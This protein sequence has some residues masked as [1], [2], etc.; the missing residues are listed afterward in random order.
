MDVHVPTKLLAL[1]VP[2]FLFLL[3]SNAQTSSN[4]IQLG[5]SIVAG[6]NKSWTSPSADFAF[7]FYPLPHGR[8][9]VGIWFDKINPQKTLVWSANRDDPAQIGS[10]INLTLSG[11][12]VLLHANGS[13][14]SIYNQ[15]NNASS[16]SMLDNGNFVLKNSLSNI[17]WESFASPT[18]TILPGQNLVM[19]QILYSNANGTLDYSTGNYKLEVQSDGNIVIAA[20]RYSGHAYWFTGTIENNSVSIVFDNNTAMLYAVNGTRNIYQMTTQS[21]LPNPIEDFYH[22]ATINDHGNF[23]QL[24]FHKKNGTEWTLIWDAITEPCLVDAICGVNGFCTSPDNKVINCSCLPGY[25]PLDPYVPSKGCYR[26][27]EMDFCAANSSASDFTVQEI[28]DADIPNLNFADM[29][30]I[31]NSDL[32]SCTREVM[33]DCFCM[34]GVLIGTDCF[35]K[36]TPLLNGRI[37]IPT[38]SKRVALVKVPVVRKDDGNDSPSWIVLL[39]SF[40]SCSLLALVF[41]ASAVHHNPKFRRWIRKEPPPNPKPVDINLKTFSFQELREATKGFKNKLGRGAF[42]TVYSGILT[43]EGEQVE[44][45]VKQLEKAEDQD[46]IREK[47]FVTE[48]QVIGLTH[49]RNLVRLL[50]FCNER[51]HRLLVYEMMKNGSLSSLLFG[52]GDKPR[53]EDRAK[54]ALEVARGLLYLHE[55]CDPQIIHCDIK[56]QNVLLDSNYTAKVSDFGVAKLLKKDRTRTSTNVR[57]TMGY[58]APEWLKN[59]PVTAKVDVYSFGVMLLETIFCRRHIELHPSQDEGEGEDMILIDWVLYSAKEGNLRV[60]VDHDVEAL[61][62]FNRFERMTM[63]GLWCLSPNPAVRPTMKKV[64]QMLEGAMEVGVPPLIDAQM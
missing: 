12:L 63:V 9:L 26:N 43:L 47:E 3:C 20:F 15:T 36:R 60:M 42:G 40:I 53:W 57:G 16:A 14:V 56:P 27:L 28:S 4:S 7:G 64:T 41:A 23:E 25:T 44:V 48:V 18:D 31:P 21:Q 13:L 17:I 8:Y 62:D 55:E 33:S 50:G 37:S 54:I 52:E 5:S 2:F 11:Q 51:N 46:E 58:M 29:Q 38:T 22:R 34:A 61:N 6:S 19:S 1:C 32:I 39:V 35:K 30:W 45:A 59:A 10:T 24:I 49:H